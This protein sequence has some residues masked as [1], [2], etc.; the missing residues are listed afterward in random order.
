MSAHSQKWTLID[1]GNGYYRLRNVNSTLV[2]GVAQSS[3][4]DGAAI[5]QW[6]SLNVDDQLWKIVRIN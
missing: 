3:T 6:N 4:T 5:V 2:A 1:A